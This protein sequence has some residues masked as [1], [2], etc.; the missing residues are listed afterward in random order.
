MAV[1]SMLM[2]A[3]RGR[4][5]ELTSGS[6]PIL[7]EHSMVTGRVAAEEVVVKATIMAGQMPLMNLPKP[8]LDRNWAEMP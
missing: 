2:V 7:L 6:A 3:P 4:T 5:K 1:P 8:T